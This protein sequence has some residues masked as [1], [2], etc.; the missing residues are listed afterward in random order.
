MGLLPKETNM[1]DK[2]NASGAKVPCISLLA[3]SVALRDYLEST[4]SICCPKFDIPDNLWVSFHNAI[5]VEEAAANIQTCG[6]EAKQED[7][8]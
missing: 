3:A 6:N 5:K 7:S 8:E 2:E 1:S 4:E